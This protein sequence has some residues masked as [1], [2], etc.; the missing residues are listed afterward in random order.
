M[1]DSTSAASSTLTRN[2]IASFLGIAAVLAWTLYTLNNTKEEGAGD[3]PL[4]PVVALHRSNARRRPRRPTAH[5]RGTRAHEVRA[6]AGDGAAENPEIHDVDD[7]SDDEPDTVAATMAREFADL[8]ARD[9][10]QD[11]DV[12]QINNYRNPTRNGH[13]VVAMIYAISEEQTLRNACKHYTHRCDKC[14]EYPIEGTRWKCSTCPDS[15]LCN[16]C[17]KRGDHDHRRHHFIEIEEPAMNYEPGDQVPFYPGAMLTGHVSDSVSQEVANKLSK[18]TTLDQPEIQSLWRQWTFYADVD[19]PD[20]PDGLRRVMTRNVFERFFIPTHGARVAPPN[21][22]H[23]RLFA[24][25]DQDKDGNISFQE[26]LQGLTWRKSKNKLK[27]VFEAYDIN[28]DEYVERGDFLRMFRSFYVYYKNTSKRMLS[29]IEDSA[30]DPAELRALVHGRQPLTS[31]FARDGAF[32]ES[33]ATRYRQTGKRENHLGETEIVDGQGVISQDG[34]DYNV[35][36]PVTPALGEFYPMPEANIETYISLL[37]DP[38]KSAEGLQKRVMESAKARA[39]SNGGSALASGSSGPFPERTHQGN[40]F[41]PDPPLLSKEKGTVRPEFSEDEDFESDLEVRSIFASKRTRS[42]S[43]VRFKDDIEGDD[44]DTRSNPSTSSRS[45]PERWGGFEISDAE[46]DAG[47]EVMYQATRDGFMELLDPLLK[48][49]EDKALESKKTRAMRAKK[50]PLFGNKYFQRWARA[51]EGLTEKQD[52]FAEDSGPV[53]MPSG[54]RGIREAEALNRHVERQREVLE[55]IQGQIDSFGGEEQEV[56]ELDDARELSIDELLQMSG[57][58]VEAEGADNNAAADQHCTERDEENGE[59]HDP[60]SNIIDGASDDRMPPLEEE[61]GEEMPHLEEGEEDDKQEDT[62]EQ[63]LAEEAEQREAD[64]RTFMDQTGA[65]R[66]MAENF[67]HTPAP[68]RCVQDDA[69]IGAFMVETDTESREVAEEYL[70][71]ADGSRQLAVQMRSDKTAEEEVGEQDQEEGR[72]DQDNADTS[73]EID[74]NLDPDAVGNT[75]EGDAD[76]EEEPFLER[77]PYPE[78][79]NDDGGAARREAFRAAARRREI[80]EAARN[81]RARAGIMDIDRDSAS[82]KSEKPDSEGPKS[83]LEEL[84]EAADTQANVVGVDDEMPAL[85]Q[86]DCEENETETSRQPFNTTVAVHG[87][88]VESD[89]SLPQFRPNGHLDGTVPP[90][91][92]TPPQAAPTEADE[93]LFV[94]QGD[95]DSGYVADVSHITG[96]SSSQN[97]SADQR[98]K[99][100]PLSGL[101]EECLDEMRADAE[102]PVKTQ[103]ALE[104]ADW[105]ALLRLRELQLVEEE[106][107]RRKG[108]ARLNFEEFEGMLIRRGRVWEEVKKGIVEEHLKVRGERDEG[109]WVGGD[110]AVA[111]Q[112]VEMVEGQLGALERFLGSWMDECI[113]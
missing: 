71:R 107:G 59:A 105:V 35:E 11:T 20:H 40:Q 2:R 14:G 64:I 44:Y 85:E 65:N 36:V 69:G 77:E 61:E 97:P 63:K 34:N 74:F 103:K 16:K 86:A 52:P 27:R 3:P 4:H 96:R 26:Y 12:S 113:R 41:A 17:K 73:R 8:V 18:E 23:D 80:A 42:E 104:A 50:A 9:V 78:V 72:E 6:E 22:I 56:V 81:A 19:V 43:K 13:S 106:A 5:P 79:D 68:E 83:A 54:G 51:V 87:M 112:K 66:Q 90:T 111:M 38:P 94:D 84:P 55:E 95:E 75:F 21:L 31:M 33:Q 100:I 32:G 60:R 93:S 7:T 102:L 58:A 82:E 47:K 70:E 76:D 1:A 46:R 48:H 10:D 57:F 28:E 88:A 62:T 29:M 108:W 25:Y 49:F 53:A 98:N 101:K 89:A 99:K 24:F 45:I 109:G 92:P 67:L 39:E 110:V 30:M 37:N 91:V 15:D